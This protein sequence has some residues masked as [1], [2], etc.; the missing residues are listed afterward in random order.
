[1]G[2]TKQSRDI[3]VLL[4]LLFR[5]VSQNHVVSQALA[6]ENLSKREQLHRAHY[7]NCGSMVKHSEGLQS[8]TFI[9]SGRKNLISLLAH[10]ASLLGAY[11]VR[12]SCPEC[13]TAI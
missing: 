13:A 10:L 4:P 6:M 9:I 1:M 8:K 7:M 12:H 11:L 3:S 5:K 2:Q